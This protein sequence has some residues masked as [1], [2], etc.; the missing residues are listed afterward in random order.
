MQPMYLHRS[1][2][3]QEPPIKRNYDKK[4][5]PSAAYIASLP[6]MMEVAHEAIQ[7]AHVPIPQ[8]GI[9]N[10]KLPLRYRTKAAKLLTLE[11]SVTGT[12]SLQAER[13]RINMSRI[14]RTFSAH[15]DALTTA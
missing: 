13:R 5:R 3:G 2:C 12:A 7:G 15:K 6:D 10:F 8:G 14:M 11:T 9:H 4:F 1:S